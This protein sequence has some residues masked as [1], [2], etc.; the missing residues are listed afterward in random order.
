MKFLRSEPVLIVAA[1]QAALTLGAAFGLDFSAAQQAALVGFFSAVLAVVV[2]QAVSSPAVVTTMVTDAATR[3]AERLDA[4]A[5]GLGGQ[6]TDMGARIVD[7]VTG[8][9]LGKGR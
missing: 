1:V 7:G 4:T 6:I 5:A 2:R 3:T 9:I 8:E